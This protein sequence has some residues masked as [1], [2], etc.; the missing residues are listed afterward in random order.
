M[1]FFLVGEAGISQE[2]VLN[3]AIG[4]FDEVQIEGLSFALLA[5]RLNAGVMSLYGTAWPIGDCP[6]PNREAW[7]V[8]VPARLPKSLNPLAKTDGSYLDC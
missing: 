5:R 1:V 6:V 7:I 2:A 3:L 4:L 8:A